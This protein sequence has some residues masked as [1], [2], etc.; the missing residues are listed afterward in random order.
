MMTDKRTRP[1][2]LYG[3]T[4]RLVTQCGNLYVTVNHLEGTLFEVFARLGKSGGCSASHNEA[5]TRAISLGLRCGVSV[6]EYVK[7]MKGI[8][9]PSPT[10]WPEEN[11]ILSCADAI[12]KALV[13]ARSLLE[14]EK[15]GEYRGKEHE[16][17]NGVGVGIAC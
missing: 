17:L 1:P 15:N 3:W 4:F 16:P 7:N 5:L 2:M 11:Q 14:A 10:M 13:K 9:C 6:D 12:G 8:Q